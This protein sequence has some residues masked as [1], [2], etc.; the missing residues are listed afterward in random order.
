MN[1]LSR[2]IMLLALSI[3]LA[4]SACVGDPS[5]TGSQEQEIFTDVC[6]GEDVGIRDLETGELRLDDGR[7]L[8]QEDYV[9]IEADALPAPVREAL[10][11][12]DPLDDVAVCDADVEL[13]G[14]SS[15]AAGVWKDRCWC[16]A[17]MAFGCCFGYCG[18]C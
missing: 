13:P 6:T 2:T 11:S 3:A 10:E 9:S 8:R 17:S 5:T 7:V 15:A 1:A 16:S 4:T 14:G 18:S 12:A